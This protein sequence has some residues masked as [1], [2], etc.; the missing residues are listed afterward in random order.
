[1]PDSL[2][3]IGRSSTLPCV[4]YA[5]GHQHVGW[6]LGGITGLLIAELAQGKQ[7]SV[8]LAP[9][10]LDRFRPWSGLVPSSLSRARRAA[11]ALPGWRQPA[12]AAAPPPRPAAFSRR[13]SSSSRRVA[14]VAAGRRGLSSTTAP[15]AASRRGLSSRSR[16]RVGVSTTRRLADLLETS[17]PDA[18]IVW[19]A[20]RAEHMQCT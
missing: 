6:T 2:P 7:P 20:V 5:F 4:L 12:S 8:D 15:V 1:M 9:Y 3:V 13:M 18:S 16:T 10:S 19:M 17:R 11:A 14:P